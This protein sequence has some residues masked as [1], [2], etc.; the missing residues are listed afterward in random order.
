[1]IAIRI[2][3]VT[4]SLLILVPPTSNGQDRSQ[5]G[6]LSAL[7]VGQIVTLKEDAGRYEITVLK[8]APLGHKIIEIGSDYVVIEDAARVTETRIPVYSIKAI[9]RLR[10]PKE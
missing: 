6:F 5:K 2:L 4:T 9:I 10:L 8:K 7:K 3:F 1:M